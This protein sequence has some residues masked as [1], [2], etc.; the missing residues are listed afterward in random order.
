MCGPRN[1]KE[2]SP[3]LLVGIRLSAGDCSRPLGWEDASD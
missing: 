2:F 1:V 3:F